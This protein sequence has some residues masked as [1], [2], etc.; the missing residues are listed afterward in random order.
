MSQGYRVRSVHRNTPSLT[1]KKSFLSPSLRFS[2]IQRNSCDPD[3]RVASLTTLS[4]SVYTRTL[5]SPRNGCLFFLGPKSRMMVRFRVVRFLWNRT[6]HAQSVFSLLFK[7]M[8]LM[9]THQPNFTSVHRRK[10]ARINLA[11]FRLRRAFSRF[12]VE[13]NLRHCSKNVDPTVNTDL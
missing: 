13:D 2:T 7:L 1:C 11:T 5:P 6:R 12:L 8:I 3:V 9:R 10:V 4:F